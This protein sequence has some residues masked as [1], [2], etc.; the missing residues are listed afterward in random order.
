M[1]Q[2]G[3]K[4]K[5]AEELIADALVQARIRRTCKGSTIKNW[6]DATEFSEREALAS[7]VA[8]TMEHEP[9]EKWIELIP[10][11]LTMALARSFTS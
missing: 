4:R 5:R 8:A 2:Q 6:I 3:C 1:V 9:R 7:E 10:R 11:F